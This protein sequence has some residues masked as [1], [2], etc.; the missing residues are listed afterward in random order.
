MIEIHHLNK[1]RSRRITWLLEELG[2]P[3]E[4]IAYQR[5]PETGLAP[6]TLKAIHPL[7]KAP[8]MRDGDIVLSESGAIVQYLI[9]RYGAGKFAPSPSSADY[10]AYVHFLHYAE[11]SAMLP[12]MLKLYTG[13]LGEAGTPLQP[14]IQSEILTHFGY[15]NDALAG[16]EYFV[17]NSLT[18]ADIQLSFPIQHLMAK[19]SP[20]VFANLH[21]YV[22]RI[23][24]RPAYRRAIDQSGA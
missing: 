15:L 12:L 2:T 23:E 20:E 18:G 11:G 16:R 4:V 10:P 8:I 9:E 19:T 7:G 6:D 3:Y 5:D 1:S 24:A 14:R 13:R 22:Q 21:A 17:G